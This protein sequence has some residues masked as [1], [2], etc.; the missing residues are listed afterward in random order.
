MFLVVC[1]MALIAFI[2]LEACGKDWVQSEKNADRRARYIA[3]AISNS[4]SEIT[5]CYQRISQNQI[6]YYEQ[7][8]K[9]L[10]K[11]K[12]FKDEHGRWFRKR[13]IYDTNG[14]IIAEE[15]VGI[16]R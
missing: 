14:N 11:E 6:D 7:M 2:I 16:E 9:D 12:E 13:F 8:R 5:S 4:A 10:Q 1:V 3:G 15:I